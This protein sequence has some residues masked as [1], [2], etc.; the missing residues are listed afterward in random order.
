MKAN[1]KNKNNTVR[2]NLTSRQTPETPV[3]QETFDRNL[4]NYF[5]NSMIAFQAVEDPYFIKMMEDLNVT[6]SGIKIPG[7][8]SLRNKIAKQAFNQICEI[9]ENRAAVKYLCTTA[10]V[11]SE[12][13]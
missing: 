7:R 11:W 1:K 6:N 10:D 9:K 3:T 12:V 8:R 13:F 5:V 4:A 2:T